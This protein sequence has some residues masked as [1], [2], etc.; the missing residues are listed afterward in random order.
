MVFPNLPKM[1]QN[2]SKTNLLVLDA[3]TASALGSLDALLVRLDLAARHG[4]HHAT[5]RLP[6]SR[7]IAGCGLAEEVDLDEVALE[8]AL[9]RDD[10]LDEERVGVL[11][12]D[13]HD[14]HHADTHQLRLVQFAELLE[15]VGLDRGR[16]ELG[17]FA[18]TH[19]GGLDVLD[20]R[21]VWGC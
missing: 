15:V 12:V 14:G 21:H 6:W 9:E 10:G 5:S 18:G 16:D 4:A 13:V 17:L 20:D 11:E 19:R 2:R 3:T 8:R 7:Q 1:N